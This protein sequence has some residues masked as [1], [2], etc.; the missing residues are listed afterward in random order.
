MDRNGYSRSVYRQIAGIH[1]SSIDKGF[2]S[3]LGV[4]VLSLIYEAIDAD[5]NSILIVEI[6]NNEVVG[7][8][9]AGNGISSIYKELIYRLPRIIFAL[10]PVLISLT[11]IKQILEIL[12]HESNKI[13]NTDLPSVEL[14][15]IAVKGTEQRKGTASRLYGKLVDH[16]REEGVEEFRI[17]VGDSLISAHKFY[18]QMGAIPMRKIAVH[19]G[20]ESTIYRHDLI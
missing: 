8:V 4:S 19:K 3:S 10:M 9:A 7:F 16:F 1:A 11:K 15:S 18:K 5:Q 13:A 14:Y 20:A 12:Q 2:L 17:I 6:K